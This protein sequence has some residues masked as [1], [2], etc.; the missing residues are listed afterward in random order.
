MKRLDVAGRITLP[1]EIRERKGYKTDDL[2]EIYERDD[3]IILKPMTLK[4]V[5]DDDQ[6]KVLRKLYGIVKDTDVLDESEMGL[7]KK[8]CNVADVMCPK[9]N[10][11]LFLTAE[12]TYVCAK[13]G[14]E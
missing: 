2:F 3:E 9:C 10:E 6:M 5:I 8:M 13:C 7:L 4:Y 1:K 14:E 11:S 12:N